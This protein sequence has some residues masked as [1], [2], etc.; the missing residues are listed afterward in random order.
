MVM[1][2]CVLVMFAL[3][4]DFEGFE[5]LTVRAARFH[6]LLDLI[7]LFSVDFKSSDKLKISPPQCFQLNFLVID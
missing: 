2:H 7:T 6:W 5:M 4:C 3:K 1:L